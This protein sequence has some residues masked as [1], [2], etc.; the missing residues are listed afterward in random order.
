VIRR[1]NEQIKDTL[2]AEYSAMHEVGCSS[3]TIARA[4]SNRYNPRLIIEAIQE[5]NDARVNKQ[6]VFMEKMEHNSNYK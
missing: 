3:L 5:Y 2:K 6:L 1:T 4:L